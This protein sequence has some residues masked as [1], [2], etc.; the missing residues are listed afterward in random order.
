MKSANERIRMVS[1]RECVDNACLIHKKMIEPEEE[2][3]LVVKSII[4]V[5]CIRK[6]SLKSSR[7]IIRIGLINAL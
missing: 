3:S 5:K 1:E 7:I 2:K 4:N 6:L